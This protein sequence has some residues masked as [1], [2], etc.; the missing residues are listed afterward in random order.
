MRSLGLGV[1]GALPVM[2][3]PGSPD[4]ALPRAGAAPAPVHLPAGTRSH[5]LT[6]SDGTRLHY[7]EAGP[8]R[9]TLPQPP[10]TLAFVPGWTMPA[11]I[12]AA[13]IEHFAAQLRV[14]ALDPRGQGRSDIAQAGY[15]HGRR[16]TDIA[17]F[18][19]AARAGDDVVLVGWS[20]GVLE[21]LQLMHDARAAGRAA[22]VRALV[23]V[24]NSVG[25]GDP[26]TGDPTFFPRLR[27]RRR[28]TVAGFCSAMFK[29]RKPEARWLDELV[30]AALRMPL[31]ASIALLSQPRAR[32]FWRDALYATPQPVLYAY[33]PRFA[34][35]AEIVKAQMPQLQTALFADAGHAL[36]V[37]DAADFNARLAT[38]L[39]RVREPAAGAQG[40]AR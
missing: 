31:E 18:L 13:Q 24:D 3:R 25:V 21:S 20:L 19:A 6:T 5:W 4:P 39:E 40:P 9:G 15:D 22:P 33:T 34:Q 1:A 29:K 8:R 32:E 27:A 35:Q 36:F 7:L 28:E 16:A 10:T 17:E 30:N 12:W 11:W 2:A 23:L 37:D 38:F 26:P 14:L